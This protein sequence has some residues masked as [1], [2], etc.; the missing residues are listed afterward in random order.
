LKRSRKSWSPAAATKLR[1]DATGEEQA[2]ED[3]IVAGFAAAQLQLHAMRQFRK[4]EYGAEC[5]GA[6][7]QY[8]KLLLDTADEFF[9]S[10]R[11]TRAGEIVNPRVREFFSIGALV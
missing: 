1:D 5:M 2:S 11:L 7:C 4:L 9:R 10:T 8:P 6:I 3:E